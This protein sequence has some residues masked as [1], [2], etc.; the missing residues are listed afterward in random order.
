MTVERFWKYS[1]EGNQNALRDLLT[2]MPR[3]FSNKK[4]RC[5][6]SSEV[7]AVQNGNNSQ[8]EAIF[9]TNS[10]EFDDWIKTSLEFSSIIKDSNYQLTGNSIESIFE[11]EAI[12]KARYETGGI[13][14][15]L[16]FLLYQENT[17]WKIFAIT[18]GYAVFNPNY[19]N[20]K[21]E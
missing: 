15:P 3:S 17:K 7:E 2:T 10:G 11:R 21:C 5:R 8:A 20:G 6:S 14:Q 13:D 4:S 18:D 16:Y 9:A 19:A 12:I 1:L